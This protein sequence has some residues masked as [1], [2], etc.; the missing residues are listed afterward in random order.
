M[1]NKRISGEAHDIEETSD[2]AT[3]SKIEPRADYAPEPAR[4]NSCNSF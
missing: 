4:G 2:I 1:K 3:K